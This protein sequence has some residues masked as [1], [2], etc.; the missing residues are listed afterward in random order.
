[1][2]LVVFLSETIGLP[3]SFASMQNFRSISGKR[4]CSLGDA[5]RMGIDR[6]QT[7]QRLAGSFRVVIAYTDLRKPSECAKV[8]RL[9]FERSMNVRHAFCI[10]MT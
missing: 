9:E 1:M 3:R 6:K 8:A 5:G 4:R 10:S 2:D 7:Q